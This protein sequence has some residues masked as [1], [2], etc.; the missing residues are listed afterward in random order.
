MKKKIIVST[1]FKSLERWYLKESVKLY[2]S[3]KFTTFC[4]KSLIKF[5]HNFGDGSGEEAGKIVRF[6]IPIFLIFLITYGE[7]HN[8]GQVK[9]A[10]ND[11]IIYYQNGMLKAHLRNYTKMYR[12]RYFD[13]YGRGKIKDE[14]LTFKSIFFEERS[15]FDRNFFKLNFNSNSL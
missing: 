3:L 14:E 2:G 4:K 1:F 7:I 9:K 8:Q 13:L 15:I 5:S 11:I 12:N 6:D 10:G